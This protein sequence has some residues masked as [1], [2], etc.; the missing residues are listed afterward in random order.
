MQEPA[1]VESAP[2][3]LFTVEQFSELRRAWTQ[4]GLRN[5]ILNSADRVNSRGERIPGNG[6]AEAGAI[7]RVGRRVLIDEGKFFLWIAQQQKRKAAA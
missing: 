3:N 7:I 1:V 6:L 4:P 2:R 5:L